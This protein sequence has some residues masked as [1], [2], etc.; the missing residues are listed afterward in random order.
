MVSKY[1]ILEISKDRYIKLLRTSPHIESSFSVNDLEKGQTNTQI[2]IIPGNP[3]IVEFYEYFS[4]KLCNLTH[5]PVLCLSHTNHL[6]DKERKIKPRSFPRLKDQINDKITMLKRLVFHKKDTDVIFIG[7][8]IGCYIIM[9]II[10]LLDPEMRDRVKKAYLLFPTI[11]RM[12]SSPNGKWLTFFVK[13]FKWLLYFL[14]FLSA[15][16]PNWLRKQVLYW[17]YM[18]KFRNNEHLAL[19]SN[20]LE[21]VMPF[22]SSY[23]SFRNCLDMGYDEMLEVDKL[24]R[25]LLK[26][27]GKTLVFYYG[28]K[29]AWC[30][31]KYYEDMKSS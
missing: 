26:L 22:S 16:V 11:E 6:F 8:S 19:C 7:H 5:L 9:H 14:I 2:V 18:R 30:P 31:I 12:K 20:F 15:K 4:E 25:N 1:E 17:F 29:D 10:A 21:S 3:G 28:V 27:G 23:Y 13:N 24:D